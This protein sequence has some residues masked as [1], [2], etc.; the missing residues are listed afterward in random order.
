MNS[1]G[2]T[3]VSQL[4]RRDVQERYTGTALGAFW[5][6]AQPL[7]MLLVYALVFGEVL[8]LRTGVAHDSGQFAVWL[9]AGLMAF[10]GLAEVLARAPTLLTERR[11]LLLNTPLPPAILPLLPVGTSLVLELISVSLLMV[12]LLLQGEAQWFALLCYLPFLFLRLLLSLAGAYLLAILGVFLRDL[13]Q[14]MPPLLTVLLLVSPI[15]YPL[16]IVPVQWLGWFEWNPLAHLV[17]GY[18]AALLEG[19]FLWEPFLLLAVFAG[20]LLALAAWLSQRLMAQVRY[21]L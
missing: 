1:A 10:N 18:R 6:V 19:R 8:Q 3:I 12:W 5:L 20:S 21:V 4:M 15:V 14:L 2:L 7:F 13:R 9:F 16:E 11:E 17:A